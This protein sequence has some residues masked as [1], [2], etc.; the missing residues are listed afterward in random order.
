MVDPLSAYDHRRSL[1]EYCELVAEFI[2]RG[3]TEHARNELNRLAF[4]CRYMNQIEDDKA[5]PPMTVEE[6]RGAFEGKK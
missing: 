4:M 2:R 5:C 1:A 3:E 6:L